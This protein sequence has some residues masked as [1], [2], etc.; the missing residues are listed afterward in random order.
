MNSVI[1]K[2]IDGKEYKFAKLR[3]A[4]VG[5]LLSQWSES[6]RPNQVEI[7]KASGHTK[8]EIKT[9]MENWH[10]M[11]QQMKFAMNCMWLFKYAAQ[12]FSIGYKNAN[13]DATDEQVEEIPMSV[14][15]VILLAIE[16][17]TG[18][19]FPDEQKKD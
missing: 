17:L 19:K 5:E 18:W 3:R 15:D 13:P 2:T 1:I 7:L 10:W 16:L 11:S 6:E 4:Q 12:V 9:E 8:A 14:D